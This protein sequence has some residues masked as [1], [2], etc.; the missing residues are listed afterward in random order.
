MARFAWCTDIHLDFIDTNKTIAFINALRT[1]NIDGVLLTGDISIANLLPQHLGMIEAGLEVPI[2]FVLGNHDYFGSSIED[3]RKEMK[4]L[5]NMSTHLKYLATT[6]YVAL[7]STTAVV[8]HDGWYDALY[9][10]WKSGRF[11][12]QDFLQIKDFVENGGG[13]GR[14]KNGFE[15][16]NAIVTKAQE[17]AMQ[18]VQHV[19]DGIKAAVRYHKNIIVMTHFPPFEESHIHNGR[20]GAAYAQP[21]YTSKLMGD[22]LRQAATA[23][24]AVRFTVLAGHTHGKFDGEIVKN[25]TCHVGGVEYGRPTMQ[26]IVEVS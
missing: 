9:G 14:F 19:H 24:P 20:V 23:F 10:D 25:M 7:S 15:D 26:S 6:P 22:M 8:G 2:Y 5:S 21:W 4:D 12:M 18:G 3:V 11:V 16:M 1:Q 13:Q 17:L